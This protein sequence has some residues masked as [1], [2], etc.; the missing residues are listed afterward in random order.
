[1]YQA[2]RLKKAQYLLANTDLTMGEI[3]NR[4]GYNHAYPFIR[5]FKSMY[6]S[7]LANTKKR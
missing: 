7:V 4:I 5:F 6:G 2:Q 1:M 3:A